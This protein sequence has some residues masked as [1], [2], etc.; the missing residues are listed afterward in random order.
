MWADVISPKQPT[1]KSYE[2][3]T[4][5]HA[6]SNSRET[7]IFT[8]F[9][10]SFSGE[11]PPVE[12][13]A[14]PALIEYHFLPFGGSL[15]SGAFGN[16]FGD[17]NFAIRASAFD[18]MG[19]FSEDR[20]LSL[21]DWEFLA[22]AQFAGYEIGIIPKVLFWKRTLGDS[23]LRANA[24]DEFRQ[25][26]SEWRTLKPYFFN[27][28][29]GAAFP[30]AWLKRGTDVA[31]LGPVLANSWDD[32]D[33]RQGTLGWNMGYRVRE[34]TKIAGFRPFEDSETTSNGREL[35]GPP[36]MPRWLH[37]SRGKQ[38][39]AVDTGESAKSYMVVRKW[40]SDVAVRSTTIKVSVTR[41][42]HVVNCG[43]GAAISIVVFSS[44]GKQ[45]EK[46]TEVFGP[47]QKEALLEMTSVEMQVGMVV[48]FWHD[49]RESAECDE[50]WLRGR[51]LM[52][53][54][55]GN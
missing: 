41:P 27:L 36:P 28:P 54:E 55:A 17:A 33:G 25:V 38:H 44:Q 23:M 30:I 26:M 7:S 16:T 12:P 15:A 11:Q 52:D 47:K 8:C 32:W 13:V 5:V 22:R 29:P 9:S 50:L 49:P 37:V 40:T 24:R 10:D 4:F 6:L 3:R 18:A 21:E 43:D 48:E 20:F 34:D 31:K 45:L 39:G 1:A 53:G 19:G 14:N 35:F 42:D 51:V 46:K 2:I